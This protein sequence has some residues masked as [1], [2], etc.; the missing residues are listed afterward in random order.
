[1]KRIYLFL[2]MLLACGL[3]MATAK[4]FR[5]LNSKF[6]VSSITHDDQNIYIGT[7]K[8]ADCHRQGNGKPD[9]IQFDKFFPTGSS[10]SR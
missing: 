1:M 5:S 6:L 10:V 3:Q 8:R 7:K 9:A 4:S 2:L